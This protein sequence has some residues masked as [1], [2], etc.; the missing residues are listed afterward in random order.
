MQNY[1]QLQ[2]DKRTFS[3]KEE[4]QRRDNSEPKRIEINQGWTRL[5]LIANDDLEKLRLNFLLKI[6]KLYCNSLNYPSAFNLYSKER[7]S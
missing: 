1:L 2:G 4:K 7:V 5:E 3:G 6:P